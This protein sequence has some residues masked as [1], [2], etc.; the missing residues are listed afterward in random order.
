MRTFKVKVWS[1]SSVYGDRAHTDTVAMTAFSQ[2][3]AGMLAL[4]D[5][6]DGD[7]AIVV[8]YVVVATTQALPMPGR[9]VSVEEDGKL[10]YCGEGSVQ[11]EA[12]ASPCMVVRRA[13]LDGGQ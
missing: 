3:I 10:S 9:V 5:M 4:R 8:G 6:P 11:W 2:R 13:E 12:L 7:F 1:P